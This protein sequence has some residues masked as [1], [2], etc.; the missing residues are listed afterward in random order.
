MKKL[1]LYLF[2]VIVLLGILLGCGKAKKPPA[3]SEFYSEDV[4]QRAQIVVDGA[5]H[6]ISCNFAEEALGKKIKAVTHCNYI[7]ICKEEFEPEPYSDDF[8]LLVHEM[9]HVEENG[10]NI[11]DCLINLSSYASEYAWKKY[12]QMHTDYE[13]YLMLEEEKA[14]RKKEAKCRKKRRK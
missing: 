4:V 8:C 7:Y 14:A 9:H 13:A 3:L 2:A 12:V 10:S 1:V 6:R 5:A 11:K